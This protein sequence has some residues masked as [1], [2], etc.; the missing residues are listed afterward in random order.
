MIRAKAPSVATV[1]VVGFLLTL[2]GCYSYTPIP[3]E[4]APVGQDVRVLIT[5]RGAL[6]LVEV[7]DVQGE[8]P[9]VAGQIVSQED[10]DVLLRVPVGQRREGFHMVALEQ[11]VRIPTGEILQ[12]ERRDF[13][14]GKTALLGVGFI[15]GSA[16]IITSIMNAIGGDTSPQPGPGP[17]ENRIPIPMISIPIGR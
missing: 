10:R 9:S 15:A 17:D 2:T 11:T 12:V 5:R 8:V 1:I 7:T 16:F 4:I 13:D 14:R 3:L 6:E